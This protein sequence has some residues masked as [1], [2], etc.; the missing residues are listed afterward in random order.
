MRN[1]SAWMAD[2]IIANKVNLTSHWGYEYGLTL[3]GIFGV[4][5]QTKDRR[6]LDFVIKT[7]DTF[8]NEDGTINGYRLDEFNIDHLNNGKMVLK[9]FDA[10]GAEKY[11]KAAYNLH[12]QVKDHPRTSEGIFWHKMIYPHQVWCDGLYMGAAF[13]ASFAAHF[14]KSSDFDDVAAQFVK[15]Y[16]HLKDPKTGLLYH[17]WDESKSMYWCDPETG[18]SPHFWG[19]AMGWYVMALADVIELM[20]KDHKDRE[21]LKT[22]LRQCLEALLK[23]QDPESGVWYQILDLKDRKGNY[24]EASAS[25][26]IT[27]ALFKAVKLEVLPASVLPAAKKAYQGLL[28][29]FILETKQ[30]NLNLNKICYVA[31]L[32]GKD[33][34]DGSYAYYM[35]EPIISNEPKGLGPFLFASLYSE[36][37]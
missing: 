28:D 26:M 5:Q 37:A 20:P 14:G 36:Q 8:I 24:K 19:R 18:L 10:T 16:P 33:Y 7:M 12:A 9:L 22:I 31:G 35:S 27:A 4:W 1:Y 32:G 3:E 29:E 30:G 34:R 25:C 17:A 2:S 15:S 11:K 23:V 21:A 6:Y 13:I